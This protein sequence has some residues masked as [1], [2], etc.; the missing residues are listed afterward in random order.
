MTMGEIRNATVEQRTDVAQIGDV[1]VELD[2]TTQ[3]N[4]ALAEQSAAAAESL[5]TQGE[6]LV[7]AM[8]FFRIAARA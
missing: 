2:R 5:K 1:V 3:Q 8:S 7:S 4:A 6:Q